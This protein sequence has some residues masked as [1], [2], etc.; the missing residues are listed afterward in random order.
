MKEIYD[1]SEDWTPHDRNDQGSYKKVPT[2]SLKHRLDILR[3]ILRDRK[4][5][6]DSACTSYYDIY[7]KIESIECELDDR[8][9]SDN[10][11]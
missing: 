2:K 1:L 11:I 6:M 9:E 4:E 10:P 3:R 7:Y 5:A 8:K